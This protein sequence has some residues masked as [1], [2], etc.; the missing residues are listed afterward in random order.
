MANEK[1]FTLFWRTG[2]SELVEGQD[3]AS[4]MNNAGF[5]AGALGALDFYATGDARGGWIWDAEKRNWQT[6][7]A[8]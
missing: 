5:G 1:T 7:N 2:K 3:I 6:K 4:A 8:R